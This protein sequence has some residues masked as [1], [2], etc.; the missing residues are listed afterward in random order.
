MG[1]AAGA[2]AAGVSRMAFAQRAGA[3]APDIILINGKITTL[4]PLR[5]DA[6]SLAIRD[7]L[8]LT[9]GSNRDVLAIRGPQT[10]VIDL[11]GRRVIPG[12]NDSHLHVTRGGRLYNSELRW[13]GVRSL[14][15]ALAMITEQ[16]QRTP[17]GKWIAVN[18]GWSPYQFEER[19][20]PTPE[21]LTQAAPD[22]PVLVLFLY[23]RGFFNRAAVQAL[24]I[25]PATKPPEGGR[26]EVTPDGGAILWAEPDAT[27]L[28][29]AVAKIPPM[30]PEEQI[31]SSRQFFRELNRFGL[32]SAVDAGGGGHAFPK[33]Y[34]A[35][36]ALA[37][38]DGLP[39]RISNFLFPQTA[40]QELKDLQ[41]LT[42][43]HAANVNLA[44]RLEDGFVVE[45]GGESLT[46]SAGDYENFAAPR[47]DLSTRPGW[48]QELLDVTRHLVRARWPIRI[49]ASY[50]E[51][52][53]NILGVFEEVH[54]TELAA[55][56]P[57]FRGI[58]WAIDH[59]ETVTR[60]NLERI[61]KLGGGIA[62]QDRLAFAGEFFLERYGAE[63]ASHAPP[64]R[65]MIEL[66]IPVGAGTDATRVSSYNPWV[67]LAWLVSG[68]TVGGTQ[69]RRGRQ[70]LSRGE[71]L[72][73]YTTGSTW[74]SGEE[75]R[76][77][78]LTPGQYADLC[79]LSDD[80]FDVPEDRIGAISSVLTVTGG[81]IVHGA[82]GFASLAPPSLPVVPSWSPVA[83]FGGYH[84]E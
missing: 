34:A 30:T 72:S 55:R 74:F 78:R 57:G 8:V 13:D 37:E 77:G 84:S 33:D 15:K 50:D 1:I 41:Q 76:K 83:R 12:L 19:R 2:F 6:Q 7:G 79:V 29:Q 17:A 45:G 58:R 18:G 14:R 3:D 67:S 73:L 82:E 53:S 36:M 25:T 66:G 75:M 63:A 10:H 68:K 64:I 47:P 4:D 51:S 21:E 61:A 62:V 20:L 32:T 48:R 54:R 40:H 39:I 11:D 23:S 80:Y 5:P 69:M 42:R 56:N 43:D 46:I 49:H 24:G 59:A 65:D 38:S 70:L 22:T 27:I 28:Y 60:P 44:K 81:R 26:Y 9:T 35:A 16:A 31:N 52:I 71:A